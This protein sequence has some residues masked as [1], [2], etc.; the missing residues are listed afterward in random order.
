MDLAMHYRRT[1]T[2]EEIAKLPQ[3]WCA[4]PA[5]DEPGDGILLEEN[6]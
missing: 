1:L 4:L 6:T 5:M 3:A 2:P